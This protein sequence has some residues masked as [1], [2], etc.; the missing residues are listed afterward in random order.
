MIPIPA[1]AINASR[2]GVWLTPNRAA[3]LLRDQ[4]LPGRSRPWKTSVNSDSTIAWR[5]RP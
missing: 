5:R 3:R 4:V 2:I 1:S